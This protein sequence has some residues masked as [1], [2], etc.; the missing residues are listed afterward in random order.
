MFKCYLKTT[1]LDSLI[2][3]INHLYMVVITLVGCRGCLVFGS[4]R[5]RVNLM[6][7]L[8]ASLYK[9]LIAYKLGQ[10]VQD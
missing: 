8:K 6:Q 3:L 9:Q 7:Q 10:E 2:N 1:N 4:N 5:G